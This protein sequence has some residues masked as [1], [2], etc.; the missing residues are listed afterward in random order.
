MGNDI[1]VSII[2]T[3]ILLNYGLLFIFAEK[4][5]TKENETIYFYCNATY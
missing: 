3:K 5:K 2:L 4:L 1:I